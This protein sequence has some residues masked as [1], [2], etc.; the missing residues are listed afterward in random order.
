MDIF[1]KLWV[2]DLSLSQT[3]WSRFPP[4]KSLFKVKQIILPLAIGKQEQICS[5]CF[6]ETEQGKSHF[7]SGIICEMNP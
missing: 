5:V 6:E 4:Q 7:P 3:S 1:L 2:I